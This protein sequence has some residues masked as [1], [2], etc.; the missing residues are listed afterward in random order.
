M[1]GY[2]L[3]LVLGILLI[4]YFKECIKLERRLNIL[5]EDFK[6]LQQQLTHA[7]STIEIN[8]KIY[9]DTQKLEKKLKELMKQDQQKWTKKEYENLNKFMNGR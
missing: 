1:I 9:G 5:E 7:N 2:F 4:Y 3:A 6:I 8:N